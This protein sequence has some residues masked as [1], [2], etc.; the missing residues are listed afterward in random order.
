MWLCLEVTCLLT[1]SLRVVL[2]MRVLAEALA[3]MQGN[4]WPS[5]GPGWF[6]GIPSAL[7][8]VGTW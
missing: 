7:L 1:P 2:S 3:A 8:C 4:L 5:L 6:G